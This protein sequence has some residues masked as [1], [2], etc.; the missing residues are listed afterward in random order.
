MYIAFPFGKMQAFH[1][2]KTPKYLT[3]FM[4]NEGLYNTVSNKVVLYAFNK[5]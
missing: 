2:T 5:K 1:Q 4:F 3:A